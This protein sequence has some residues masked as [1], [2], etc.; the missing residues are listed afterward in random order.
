MLKPRNTWSSKAA[1]NF[2]TTEHTENTEKEINHET[3][4]KD[5]T[6]QQIRH[7]SP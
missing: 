5:F 3:H 4:E 6:I 7:A 1:T 2:I